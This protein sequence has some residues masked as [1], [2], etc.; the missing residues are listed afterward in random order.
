MLRYI[1]NIYS[2]I[3]NKTNTYSATPAGYVIHQH[4][5][6]LVNGKRYHNITYRIYFWRQLYIAV[7]QIVHVMITR[8]HWK[9]VTRKDETCRLTLKKST[10]KYSPLKYT[11][12]YVLWL[13]KCISVCL[14]DLVWQS[15]R[16]RQSDFK[17]SMNSS[18]YN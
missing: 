14:T 5:L 8:C 12:T 4:L 15:Y 7:F 10:G 18:D 13:F 2:L 11:D 6:I 1:S 17:V 3:L 16:R 9:F